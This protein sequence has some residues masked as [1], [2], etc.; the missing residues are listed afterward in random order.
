MYK[1]I[2]TEKHPIKLWLDDIEDGVLQQAKNLANLPFV[3]KHI[4]IMPDAHFG[5][6]A[7]IGSVV[8]EIKRLNDQGIIHSIRTEKD[9]DEAPSA[10]KNIE[11]VMTNQSD[12]IKILVELKPLAVIKG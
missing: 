5:K 11:D 1:V 3:F 2:S 7:S 9:L 10:Y 8:D 12:L 6:G 4:A